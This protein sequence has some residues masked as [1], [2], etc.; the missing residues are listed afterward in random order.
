METYY[1]KLPLNAVSDLLVPCSRWTVERKHEIGGKTKLSYFPSTVYFVDYILKMA[2]LF[3]KHE[4]TFSRKR[5]GV[6]GEHHTPLC[7]YTAQMLN[8]R[9]RPDTLYDDTLGSDDIADIFRIVSILMGRRVEGNVYVRRMSGVAPCPTMIAAKFRREQ[10]LDSPICVDIKET[11]GYSEAF[12]R[13][14]NKLKENRLFITSNGEDFT[15]TIDTITSVYHPALRKQRPRTFIEMCSANQARTIL[16]QGHKAYVHDPNSAYLHALSNPLHEA[17]NATRL[18][19]AELIE[20]LDIEAQDRRYKY[21]TMKAVVT[22]ETYTMG[23]VYSLSAAQ[24]DHALELSLALLASPLLIR[25]ER[26]RAIIRE[27]RLSFWPSG[28]YCT[29]LG[30]LVGATIEAERALGFIQKDLSYS[31]SPAFYAKYRYN[32]G[33]YGDNQIVYGAKEAVRKAVEKLLKHKPTL[34]H[35]ESKDQPFFAVS[36]TFLGAQ[37]TQN[38]LRTNRM[39]LVQNPLKSIELFSPERDV[40]AADRTGLFKPNLRLGYLE[41]KKSLKSLSNLKRFSYLKFFDKE[42]L[43][44]FF[45][46][47]E[48]N[49]TDRDIEARSDDNTVIRDA[50]YWITYGPKK[51]D[52]I[53]SYLGQEKNENAISRFKLEHNVR[54]ENEAA[55]SSVI[56]DT[57]AGDEV[58]SD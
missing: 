16:H 42:D 19:N 37:V 45:N 3:E 10:F 22:A 34:Y 5:L 43:S 50:S 47:E 6:S 51:P 32:I 28:L 48:G 30:N 11:T 36:D 58:S 49:V 25:D 21:G 9:L 15:S 4:P 41:R 46:R 38:P 18:Q 20:V 57:T 14:E 24:Q 39:M 55:A 54:S 56:G 12:A 8:E 44:S 7:L 26:T 1:K 23:R 53:I 13:E 27:A 35:I 33:F 31:V 17:Y 40:F 52:Q 2:E 29:T